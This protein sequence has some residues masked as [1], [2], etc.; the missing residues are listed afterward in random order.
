M[1]PYIAG[2]RCPCADRW[3]PVGCIPRE[4]RSAKTRDLAGVRRGRER[5]QVL[6][7]DDREEDLLDQ[8]QGVGEVANDELLDV[9][10]GQQGFALLENLLEIERH[11]DVGAGIGGDVAQLAD[12][13]ERIAV[14][15]RAAGQ[16]HAV[17]GDGIE[18]RVWQHERHA[19]ALG[20]PVAG[21]QGTGKGADAAGQSAEGR[22]A[23]K[24]IEGG[25]G[26]GAGTGGQHLFMHGG[27]I[28]L[29]PPLDPVGI[30][31]DPGADGVTGLGRGRHAWFSSSIC[32]LAVCSGALGVRAD[33]RVN[34]FT[35]LR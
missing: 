26:R 4:R 34:Y 5:G 30:A 28:D 9:A 24:E 33:M 21:L 17:I 16:Q 15:H 18:G 2:R 7:L 35:A 23:A 3:R 25:R 14:D 10:G 19:G 8:R 29:G 22:R 13:I 20:H 27:G 1:P 11:H 12:G 6:A 31:G 32:R